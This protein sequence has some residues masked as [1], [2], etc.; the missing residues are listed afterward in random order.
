MA[1]RADRYSPFGNVRNLA[2]INSSAADAH[3]HISADG[4]TI[5]FASDRNGDLQ[6]FR[7]TRESLDEPF[8]APE[9]LWFF[10]TPGGST[11]YPGLSADGTALYF[12]RIFPGESTDIWVSYLIPLEVG[13]DIK[14]GACP[15]P[16]NLASRGVLPVAIS[17]SEDFDV[18]MIDVATI[19]FEGI[20]PIRSNYEDIATPV[21]DGNVCECN[22]EGPDGYVDL[23]LKF[24][25]QAIVEQIVNMFGDL[26]EDD[27]LVLTLTGTLSDGTHIEGT[28]CVRIVGRLPRSLAAKRADVNQD[29]IVD[30]FDF[31]TMTEYW[32][33]SSAIDY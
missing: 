29:G 9:H 27:E 13:V 20:A 10:D 8:G 31:C 2:E 1:T 33:E 4:L 28:D 5:Y 23:T 32:L 30:L 11:D 15:N 16:L 12:T 7:A 3:P 17:G 19:R 14:P 25:T 22:T 18:D 26:V 24:K 21:A 6:L